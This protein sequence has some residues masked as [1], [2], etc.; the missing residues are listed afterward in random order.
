MK[1]NEN[2]IL[3]IDDDPETFNTLSGFLNHPKNLLIEAQNAEKAF[4]I[5][6]EK[7]P[8]IIL[9]D[10]IMP[11]MNG[12]DVCIDLKKNELTQNIPVIFVTGLMDG[13]NKKMAFD[14]GASDY[15]T[16]PFVKEE[17]VTRVNTHI[18]LKKAIERLEQITVTDELTGVY[19]RRFAY[20]TLA[21]QM[22]I[23][24]RT[25]DSFVICYLD[26]DKLKK[27]NEQF[28]YEHGDNLI[29]TVVD[30]LNRFI[31]KSDYLFRMDG[32]EFLLLLPRMEMEDAKIFLERLKQ[33]L[34]Q[35]Y[36]QDVKV[37]FSFGFSEFNYHDECTVSE[38]IQKADSD[39]YTEQKRKKGLVV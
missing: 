30:T 18:K 17:I 24:K 32:D 12:I 4:G 2:I 31:R 21:K 37:D 9:L 8:D 3:I 11:K 29:N 20:E 27:V 15:I 33:E 5:I 19:N 38:L 6:E 39:M 1:D 25:K 13:W 34:N 10:I 23:T 26:I 16:K 22:E 7:I 28:G 36:I 35:Q 14:I